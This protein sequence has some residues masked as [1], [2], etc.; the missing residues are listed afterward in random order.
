[1][2]E[3]KNL[4]QF[5]DKDAIVIGDDLKIGQQ[6]P[7]FKAHLLDWSYLDLLKLTR[8]KVRIIA[9]VLSMET[10]VCDNEI[11]KFNEEAASLS[12]DVSIIVISADLPF[13]QNKWCAAA[14]ISQVMVVS[15]HLK[16]AFGK[17]YGC[18]L[19]DQRV[20][21]RA[22]FVVDRKNKLTY[23]DYMK[24]LGDEPDYA[25]VLQAAKKAL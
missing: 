6:A 2:I 20:L 9:S 11:R 1:M 3:R 10:S 4:I 8:G 25:K 14:G 24:A 18:L 19:K 12:K 7:S 13:T 15:D 23:V 16:V 22:I 21:R 17:K 5:G